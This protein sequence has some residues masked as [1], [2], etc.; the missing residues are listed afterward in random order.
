MM[1]RG[2]APQLDRI[3][4]TEVS[5]TGYHGVLPEEKEEG[6]EFRVDVTLHLDLNRAA[7][8]DDL[9]QTV[10]YADVA[11]GIVQRIEGPSFDLIESLADRIA[12]DALDYPGVYEVDVTVHKPQAPIPHPFADV[13]VSMTRRREIP[14]VIAM[15]ANLGDRHA[16]LIAAIEGISRVVTITTIA[17]F[18]ETDPVGPEQPV[19]LNTV[20]TGTTSLPPRA[21]LAELHGIE[22]RLGRLREVRWGPRTLD[23]DLIQ[24]GDPRRNSDHQ[25]HA[26]D[27]TL[28][29]PR[30]HE[31]AFVL[32]PWLRADPSAVLRVG[33]R[34]VPVADLVETVGRAGV[35]EID[36]AP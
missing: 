33:D 19:Y 17:P 32:V 7:R 21:L 13:T 18:V 26:D 16:S 10:N 12:A 28:P 15:G 25:E 5:A 1:R 30:A 23:L 31:R 11:A 22:A 29:H 35:H 36:Q 9:T 27:L 14:V 8:E 2:I 6:Q 24:H 34:V 20:L 3:A 4:L